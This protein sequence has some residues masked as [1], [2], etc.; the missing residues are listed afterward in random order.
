MSDEKFNLCF[1]FII[2]LFYFNQNQNQ[3]ERIFQNSDSLKKNV[4]SI[5][6]KINLIHNNS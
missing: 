3:K 5:K 6:R 2:F 4:F 1:F